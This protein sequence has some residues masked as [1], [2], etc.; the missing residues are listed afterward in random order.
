MLP[1]VFFF[2]SILLRHVFFVLKNLR[3]I[4]VAQGVLD[5]YKNYSR[6][7]FVKLIFIFL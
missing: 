1:D 3:E 4:Q 5:A 2:F 6:S 7:L